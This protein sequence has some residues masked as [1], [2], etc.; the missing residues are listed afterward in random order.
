M[1]RD[2]RHLLYALAAVPS[3]SAADISLQ[4]QATPRE[5][6]PSSPCSAPHS[7]FLTIA[8]FS[9][10]NSSATNRGSRHRFS[11]LKDARLTVSARHLSLSLSL[12]RHSDIPT[13]SGINVENWRTQGSLSLSSLQTSRG[14]FL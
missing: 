6:S 11:K 9:L 7:P 3:A 12:S 8:F 13:F 2:E 1:S 14:G 5:V 4:I 10:A